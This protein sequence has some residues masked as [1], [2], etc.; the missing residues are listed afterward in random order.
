MRIKDASGQYNGGLFWGNDYWLG[1]AALCNKLDNGNMLYY[2]HHTFNLNSSLDQ[3]LEDPEFVIT[4]EKRTI[5]K[6]NPYDKFSIPPFRLM[7]STVFFRVNISDTQ[8]REM[9]FIT[10]GLCLPQSCTAKDI[11]KIFMFSANINNKNL[12]RNVN[13]LK[14][15]QLNG[16][17]SIWNDLNFYLKIKKSNGEQTMSCHNNNVN[18]KMACGMKEP[19]SDELDIYSRIFLCFSLKANVIKICS[20]DIGDDTLAPVHGLRLYS[21]IWVV[22]CHTCLIVFQMSDNKKFR[23]EIESNVLYQLIS[24]ATFSVDTFF[25]MSGVLVSFLFFRIMSKYTKDQLI[26]AK[27]FLGDI[28]IYVSLILYRFVRLTPPYIFVIGISSISTK[29]HLSN[30]VIE[31]PSSDHVN[32]DKYWWRNI[33]YINTFFP[34]NEMCMVWS[35]YLANDTQFYTIGILI[36]LISMRHIRLA[37]IIVATLLITAWLTTGIV[38]IKTNY[39]PSTID[40]FSHYDELYDKPWT[41]FGP[42][43]IG[44]IS[45]YILNAIDCKLKLNRWISCLCWSV[46]IGF[47]LFILFGIYYIEMDLYSSAVYVS[48]S[49]TMWAMS[50]AW[51]LFA[52]VSGYGGWVEKVLCWKYM[53]PFSRLV[54]CTYLIHPVIIKNVLLNA[55]SPLHISKEIMVIY[56]LGFL[57]ASFCIAFIISLLFEAPIVSL[58]HFT[59][60]IKKTSIKSASITQQQ[61]I[62]VNKAF[63]TNE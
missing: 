19:S 58:L 28:F 1:S 18:T 56:F 42:Y 7:F 43:F 37:G 44:I 20:P 39:I 55:E 40:P 22:I 10:Q 52:C 45:G 6:R 61:Q 63:D 9:F 11:H 13:I 57:S 33:L 27:G 30:S 49:H 2:K 46:A 53:Y 62:H 25:F 31:L 14:I 24:N 17:Y 34:S 48:L 36:L 21:L 12:Q 50:I 59:H 35:W 54:Y 8:N 26:K 60:P 29:Y 3:P 41:R 23:N 32:C 38:T 51:I 5:Y 4:Y 47:M 15:R 16:E